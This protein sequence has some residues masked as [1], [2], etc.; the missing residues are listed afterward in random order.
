MC[1]ENQGYVVPVKNWK[2]PASIMSLVVMGVEWGG[3]RRSSVSNFGGNLISDQVG[4]Y[5]YPAQG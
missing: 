3:Y 1:R 4:T 2:F 5:A